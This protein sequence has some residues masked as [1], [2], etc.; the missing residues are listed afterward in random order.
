MK[1]TSNENTKFI[2]PASYLQIY[3]ES[4]SN[5]LKQ[6]KT[7]LQIREDKKSNLCWSLNWMG[8]TYSCGFIC[9]IKEFS[10]TIEK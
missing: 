1:K 8:S 10:L 5:L 6:K 2:I 3:N 4:I 9:I 7:N